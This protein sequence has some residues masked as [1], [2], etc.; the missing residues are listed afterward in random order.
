MSGFGSALVN[1]VG[2]LSTSKNHEESCDACDEGNHHESAGRLEVCAQSQ[3]GV[4]H[5]TLY[6][7]RTL[8]HAV[9]PDTLPYDLR[10]HYVAADKGR[11]AP[12]RLGPTQPPVP[13][14][15]SL[16]HGQNGKVA[17]GRAFGK[18][19]NKKNLRNM[20]RCGDP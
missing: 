6:L 13:V 17:A 19:Q 12:H 14:S 1:E 10:S 18:K 9:H 2:A 11:D 7:A 3:H 4:L 15:A 5:L 8:V 16:E 20:F